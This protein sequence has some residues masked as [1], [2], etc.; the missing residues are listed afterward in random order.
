MMG[1][2]YRCVEYVTISRQDTTGMWQ[3][4]CCV[5]IEEWIQGA[6]WI[7]LLLAADGKPYQWQYTMTR[8]K[9]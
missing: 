1:P 8:Y 3:P 5:R 7:R 4:W 6:G 9:D 2:G